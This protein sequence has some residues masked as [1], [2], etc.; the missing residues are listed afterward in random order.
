M[1]TELSVVDPAVRVGQPG[2]LLQLHTVSCQR[3][4]HY[5]RAAMLLRRVIRSTTYTMPSR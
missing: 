3:D 5:R 4:H 2:I 1:T